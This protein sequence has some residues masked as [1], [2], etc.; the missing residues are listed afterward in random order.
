MKIILNIAKYI[1]AVAVIGG[2]AL[3]F[4]AK[5]DNNADSNKAIMDTLAVM[6][7]DI[8]YNSVELSQLNESVWGIK[9]TLEDIEDMQGTQNDKIE[10]VV[11]G[12]KHINQFTPQQFEDILNEMLKKNEPQTVLNGAGLTGSTP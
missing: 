12:L 8:Q 7:Q 9:D 4:D 5:F 10:S 6:R 2:A 1:S 11:W 3:W